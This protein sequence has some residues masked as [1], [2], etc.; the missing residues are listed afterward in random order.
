MANTSST[1]REA[2][3]TPPR[4]SR[5]QL[6]IGTHVLV[7]ERTENGGVLKLIADDGTQPMEIEVTPAGPILRLRNGLA[8]SVEGSIALSGESL[9]LHAQKQLS[10]VSDGALDIRVAGDMT[11][12][13][14]AHTISARLGDV[15]L[16]ANDDVV[17]RGERIKMNC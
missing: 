6:A 11:S 4:S 17:L 8:I 1:S 12:H 5:E 7:L 9:S 15:H 14:E 16:Q 10:L 13:A 3:A 2:L